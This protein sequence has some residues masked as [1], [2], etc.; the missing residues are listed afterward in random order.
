MLSDQNKTLSYYLHVKNR[1]IATS[2]E[3]TVMNMRGSFHYTQIMDDGFLQA[4]PSF[5]IQHI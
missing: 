2:D 1:A 5:P 3:W 4:D